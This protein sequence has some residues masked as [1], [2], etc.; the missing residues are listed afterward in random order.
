VVNEVTGQCE[1]LSALEQIQYLPLSFDRRP[2]LEKHRILFSKLFGCSEALSQGLFFN[3][4]ISSKI[5]YT[6]LCLKIN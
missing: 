5:A 1:L 4:I 3:E 6:N 2:V